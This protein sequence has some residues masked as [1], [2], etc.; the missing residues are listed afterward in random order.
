MSAEMEVKDSERVVIA[1]PVASRP[2]SSFR[3]FSE[4]LTSAINASPSGAYPE[5]VVA[6]IRPKTVRFKPVANRAPIGMVPPQGEISGT[7][8]CSSEKVSKPESKSTV[9]YKP[10]AK[11]VS[12]TTASLLANLGN[13][14]VSHQ[15]TP[16]EI[17]AQ[18]Q[19][20]EKANHPSENHLTSNPY[21]K[22]PSQLEREIVEPSKMVSQNPEENQRA[23]PATTSGDRPSYDGY[24]WRKYGQKQVKGSEYPRSYYKCTHPNCPVKKKVERSFDGQIAEIVYKG[25]HNHPKPQPP[26]RQS[27][28]GQGQEFVSDGT[29]HDTSYHLWSNTH[30]E[31]T[32]GSEGRTENQNEV[33]LSVHSTC[34]GKVVTA[35]NP[36]SSG[37]GTPDNS[38]GLSGDCE[39]GSRG[40]DAED[41]EPRCKRRKNDSQ[42]NEIGIPGE[43]V[44]DPNVGVQS[45][46]DSEILGDGFRWRKY[47]QK[48]VKGNP[49]PRSYYRCTSPK[50]NVRKYVERA[51]DDPKSF[52]TTYEGKHNHEMPIARNLNPVA[53]EPDM[54][55]PNRRP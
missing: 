35:N 33:G 41:N 16:S 15:Q 31:R 3:S 8:V 47:G 52:I 49:Y 17:Q 53:S 22:L 21:L 45:S 2:C 14:Y 50:C 38:Y 30:N 29:G 20:G 26:K 5:T 24:N 9:V 36:L 48:V 27:S 11:F 37:V 10:L 43:K 46:T 4:L 28:G 51:L 40:M 55:P 23:L 19:H 39:E 44:R 34:L 42:A 7:A 12:R 6:A 32:E 54:L 1:K 25:E 13:F 18:T